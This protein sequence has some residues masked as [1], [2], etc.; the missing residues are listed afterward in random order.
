LFITEN[1]NRGDGLFAMV[2]GASG[3]VR[4]IND[5]VTSGDYYSCHGSST[6]KIWV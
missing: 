3:D 4:V 2:E 1:I 5:P 6:E